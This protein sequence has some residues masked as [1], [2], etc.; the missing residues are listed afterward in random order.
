M[1]C[2]NCGFQLKDDAAFCANCGVSFQSYY[3]APMQQPME[4][5]RKKSSNTAI[6]VTAICAAVVV[7][8]GSVLAFT[9]G[10]QF[11]DNIAEEIYRQTRIGFNVTRPSRARQ[12][13]AQQATAPL[14][15]IPLEPID[16]VELDGVWEFSH[17]E[18]VLFFGMSEFIMFTYLGN[19]SGEVFET[20]WEEWGDWRI[21]EDGR[22]FIEAEWTG[23]YVFSLILDNDT[24]IIID[25]DGEAITY[26]R[27]RG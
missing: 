14:P 23:S 4:P 24:L 3:T 27:V 16:A 10:N 19:N 1:T 5:G 18:I 17:G 26:T 9:L 21:G 15:P 11:R 12:G 6:L 13:E 8:I 2:K 25:I 7:I 20:Q 22:L